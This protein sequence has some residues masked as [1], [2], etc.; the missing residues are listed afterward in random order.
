[1]TAPVLL[2]APYRPPPVKIGE[3]VT[4]LYR[5]RECRVS[6]ISA[7]RIPWP[8]VQPIGQRGGSGLWV[9][10]EL[11]RA[12]LTESAVA[13]RYWF[14]VTKKVPWRWRKAFGVSKYGTPGS[15]RLH[16]AACDRGAAKVRGQE[17]PAHVVAQMVANG[18][19][20]AATTIPKSARE[21]VGRPALVAGARRAARHG[22]RRRTYGPVRADGRGRAVQADRSGHQTRR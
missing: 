19:R 10:D 22:I 8:R 14:G 9:N 7:G 17:R 11:K 16:L 12:I 15:E 18:K 20:N 4:C 5:D 6:S 21:T 2:G 13:L 1:M 3:R